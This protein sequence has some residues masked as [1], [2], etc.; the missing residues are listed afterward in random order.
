MWGYQRSLL[1]KRARGLTARRFDAITKPGRHGDGHGLYLEVKPSGSK[2]WVLLYTFGGRRREMGLGR[3]P[4]VSL[5][6]ARRK[7]LQLREM[8]SIGLWRWQYQ[9]HDHG[10]YDHHNRYGPLRKL[11]PLRR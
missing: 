11:S 10:H 4:H 3:Y 8:L 2:S 1:P 6:L 7:T 5:A 9:G